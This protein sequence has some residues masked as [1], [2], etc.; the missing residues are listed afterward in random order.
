M[1]DLFQGE[2]GERSISLNTVRSKL[3]DHPVLQN[4]DPK[5]VLDKVRSQWRYETQPLDLP[6]EQETLEQRVRRMLVEPDNIIDHEND[7]DIAPSTSV[8]SGLKNMLTSND[9]E[10]VKFAFKDMIL[11]SAAIQKIK[12][13]EVLEKVGGGIF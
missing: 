6:S 8:K 5:C 11:K 9:L 2:I 13:K 3:S 4:E 1:K 10:R 12:I 7:S